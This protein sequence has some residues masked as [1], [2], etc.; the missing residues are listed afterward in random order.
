MRLSFLILPLLTSGYSADQQDLVSTAQMS[1]SDTYCLTPG[2]VKA[3]AALIENIGPT[4]DPC[5]DF[6]QLACGNFLKET[7]IPSHKSKIGRFS[8]LA[9]KLNERLK[10]LF[11]SDPADDEP[12][13][14]SSVR[15]LYSSCMDEE[16]I[17]EGGRELVL[18]QVHKLGGWPVLQAHTW[19]N[20]KF[21]W[22]KLSEKGHQLGFFDGNI[23]KVHISTSNEDSTKRMIK[24]DQ[25]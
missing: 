10:K 19:T 2:C 8:L 24:I 25:P 18:H 3:A 12:V 1:T 20:D 14:F 11:E 5:Q 13:V 23:L 4:Q 17:E 7:V 6:Y 21:V 9:A 22:Q 15:R 16:Q